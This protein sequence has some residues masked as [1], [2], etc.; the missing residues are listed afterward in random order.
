M[1]KLSAGVLL[2]RRSSGGIEVLLVHPGGPFWSAKDLGAWSIPKGEHT[3]GEDPLAA[4]R[5]EFQEET[6]QQLDD[7]ELV[8][9]SEVK[10]TSGKVIRAWAIE[11]D[12]DAEAIHSNLFTMEWPPRSG[13]K[14]EFPEVDRAGWFGVEEARQK[15]HPAQ[16]AFL[17]RLVNAIRPV[18]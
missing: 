16:Q 13:K 15:I 4:A 6:G 1:S 11:G 17:D 9:L 7:G 18:S 3:A 12:C 10:L 2:Y 14:Q 5:R 8:P